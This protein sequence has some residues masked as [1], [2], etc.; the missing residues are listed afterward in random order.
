MVMYD[1]L[2]RRML[3][4]YG[5]TQVPTPN[6]DRLAQKCVTFDS[7]Y[8]GSMPCM[9][10]RRELHTGRYNF[11]H[12][13][14]GPLEP[15]DDSMPR[16]L[17][18]AGVYSHLVS[19]HY[20]YWEDGGATYHTAYSS[21]EAS[22]GQEGD[23][24]MPCPGAHHEEGTQGNPFA[25]T[26][27]QDQ[28]NR[29]F[30]G[31]ESQFP[32]AKTFKAGLDF[33]ERNAQD[34]NW[35]LQIETFDPHE[36]FFSPEEYKTLF[37]H[38][39]LKDGDD[40]PRYGRVTQSAKE[41]EDIRMRY[42]ALLAMC[43]AYLGKVL[44]AMDRHGLWED[45]ML[46]VNTDHGYLL[47]EHDWWAKCVQPFYQE[48]AHTPLFLHDPLKPEQAGMRCENLV[49]TID[50]P[51]TL[52]Q[53]FHQP[54]PPDMEGIPLQEALSPKGKHR[55]TALFGMFGGQVNVTDGQ[56][57]YMRAA[58]SPENTPL[59]EHTLMPTHMK[60]PFSVEE[61]SQ[62][63]L[64]APQP[65]SKG[66]PLLKIPGRAKHTQHTFSSALYNLQTD[67]HQ[68]HP[69]DHPE[70][71]QHM[72]KLMIQRMAENHAPEDQFHRLGLPLPQ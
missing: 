18:Q 13:S 34:D 60:A 10:A 11:L 68:E 15:F 64:A 56:W 7:S 63:E 62:A 17:K 12:R 59:Y 39:F 58:A 9:P 2:N 38:S 21:W 3:S 24:W 37:S 31:Q 42:F 67:P 54:L 30:I 48:V 69:I 71:E 29:Q 28:L 27:L 66:C 6:F 33:I 52:L 19:D 47:G 40:W 25:F 23:P 32:Q 43:D 55:Q 1:S 35:F 20:H 16:Q 46:I 41:V 51:A 50:I 44:D 5:N 57:V 61:L 53:H 22:R 70:Q 65:F 8:V 45:T 72:I 26:L 49:Q 36:P 4:P 14:W